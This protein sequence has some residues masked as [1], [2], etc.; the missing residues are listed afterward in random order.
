M[1]EEKFRD[2]CEEVSIFVK[3]TKEVVQELERLSGND[4]AKETV[5]LL[6]RGQKRDLYKMTCLQMMVNE[7]HLSVREKNTFV[8]KMNLGTLDELVIAANSRGLFNGM[9]VYFDRENGKDLDFSNGLHNLWTELLERTNERQ[10]F[11]TEL[12]GVCPSVM[13]YKIL[14]FLNESGDHDKYLPES[15]MNRQWI[16][17]MSLHVYGVLVFMSS[18]FL[19][20]VQA[21]IRRIFLDGYG[22]LVDQGVIDSGCSR[23]MTGN[24][25]YLTDY[26]EIDGGYVAFG[27]NPKGGKITGRDQKVK[28]IRCDNG[29]EFKNKEMNQFCE[30][31][32]IKREF[33]VARTP[34]QNGVAKRKNRTLIEAARTMLADSKLPTT[35]WAEAVNIAC[36]V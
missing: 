26:K 32:G 34:Q 35:F 8:S 30:R 6:R 14:K 36:Y 20:E 27:G 29:T 10:L 5:S 28:V 9:L 15:F 1:L 4:L 3:E 19:R 24:M 33:S 23:H 18:W 16:R 21:Q 12:E 7:S 25:S 17:R 31:K 2:L 22:V 11:I 13:M